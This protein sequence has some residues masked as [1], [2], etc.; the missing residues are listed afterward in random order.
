[1]SDLANLN[2]Q[3][4][5]VNTINANSALIET[6]IENTLSRDG[7]SPNSMNADIDL[8]GFDL[9]NVGNLF[10]DGDI[11]EADVIADYLDFN[12]ASPPANPGANTARFYAYDSSG[13][14]R[15][16]YKDNAGN[17]TNLTSGPTTSTDNAVA[18]YDGATGN[19]QDSGVTLDDSE[20]L[21]GVNN[22]SQTGYHD[23]VE[24]STPSNP[25]ANTVRLYAKD[26]SGASRLFYRDSAGTEISL[27]PTEIN[28]LE[29]GAVADGSTDDTAAI[30]AAM[31]A[32]LAANKTVYCP[33]GDYFIA[34]SI[35]NPGVAV[36]GDFGKTRFIKSGTG[37]MFRALGTAPTITGTTN[38]GANAT[39]GDLS[40]T[41]V[42][43]AAAS[44]FAADTYAILQADA[45]DNG[46][47]PAKI[48]EFVR[49]RSVSG[50]TVNL[51]GPLKLSY[52]TADDAELV[53]VTLLEG[54]SY[55]DIEVVMDDTVTPAVGSLQDVM[56]FRNEFCFKP[57]F[58]RCVVR[59]GIG[60]GIYFTG[61]LDA[62]IDQFWAYDLGSADDDSDGSATIGHGGYGYGIHERSLNMGL[63]ATNL[64]MER[65][66]HGYTTGA[67]FTYNRGIPIGSVISDGVSIDSK[68]AGWDT[69]GTGTEIVFNNLHAIGS[70]RTG[71]QIRSRNQKILNCSARDC[72]ASGIWVLGADAANDFNGNDVVVQNFRSYNTNYGR[73]E[74]YPDNQADW[75]ETGAI[76]VQALRTIIDGYVVEKCDGPGIYENTAA[77]NSVYR[78]GLIIDPLRDSSLTTAVSFTQTA[79]D[80]PIIDNLFVRDGV[81]NVTRTFSV[82]SANCTPRLRNVFGTGSGTPSLTYDTNTWRVL[83]SS[84]VAVPLTGTTSETTLATIAVPGH[85]LGANGILRVTT[86]MSNNN[87]GNTKTLQVK[88]NGTAYWAVAPTT[89]LTARGQ[90]QIANRNATNSQVGG[91]N[92]TGGWATA[93]GAA[94]TSSHDTTGNLNITITGTLANSGDNMTLES[95]VV[96]I[97]H[98]H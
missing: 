72:H 56:G 67:G 58:I 91:P 97:L 6:A 95:Y 26:V 86:L 10:L 64:H 14:T 62:K 84:A 81:G 52:A 77:R 78:N 79:V 57:S 5:A 88:F 1:L 50:S 76:R 93:S 66:R 59:D 45:F 53:N 32:A 13:L 36:R 2:N 34:G 44:A 51:W 7:T 94:I 18:R 15:L 61:C 74:L 69:H 46:V 73:T 3:T 11:I 65:V 68:Q 30:E 39:E 96:E 90:G 23:L 40:L 70:R 17:T 20:N 29:F 49:I 4:S 60:E 85:A 22:L 25:S 63:V 82:A 28:A 8:N 92:G 89:T 35:D 41:M 16:A 55:T 71:Y 31:A 87:S 27:Q 75:G 19:L 24:I 47:G 98:R 37:S 21:A 12:E 48:G 54:I 42:S 9:I 83:A 80:T 38:L 43:G 33:G